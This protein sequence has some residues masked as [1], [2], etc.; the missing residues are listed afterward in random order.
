SKVKFKPIVNFDWVP[1]YYHGNLVVGHVNQI[2]LAYVLTCKTGGN[3]RVTNRKTSQRALLKNFSG[4]VV[5]ISFVTSD[6]VILGIVDAIGNLFVYEFFEG[7]G[8][9]LTEKLLAN[10]LRPATWQPAVY[11]RLVWCSFIGDDD[12]SQMSSSSP[13]NDDEADNLLDDSLML[14]LTHNEL[15]ELWHLDLLNRIYGNTQLNPDETKSGYYLINSHTK[16]I[17]DAAFSPDAT[18]VAT[19]SLDGM[20]KFFQVNMSDSNIPKCLHHWMPHDGRPISFIYFLDDH[21]NKNPELVHII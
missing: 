20:V 18:A 7:T 3:V 4:A 19:A 17:I 8:E 11:H 2:Y 9:K 10:C 13:Q 16:P 21:K 14:I 12:K 15:A 6:R 1:K 5:D